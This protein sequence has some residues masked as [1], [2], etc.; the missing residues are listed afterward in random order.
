MKKIIFI[1][2]KIAEISLV[3]ISIYL[4]A[5]VGSFFNGNNQFWINV[6]AGLA[7]FLWLIGI[8]MILYVL[9]LS[10]PDFFSWWIGSNR[11]WSEN[12]SKWLKS[13]FS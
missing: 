8:S 9:Y 1:L 4:M 12:I 6:L 3:P 13:R 5:Y 2:L 11:Q 10:I 7:F